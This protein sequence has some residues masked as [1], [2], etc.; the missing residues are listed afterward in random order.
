VLPTE[1]ASL[2]SGMKVLEGDVERFRENF[3]RASFEFSHRLADHPLFELPRLLELAT[4]LPDPDVYYDAGDVRVD[5][6]WDE[7][8]RTK[9]T[10]SQLIERIEN[11]GAWIILRG[12]HKDPH[13]SALIQQCLAEAQELV[14]PAF[15]RRVKCV[16]GLIF[17][18]SP[19][20]VTTYHIDRECNFLM[21][22]HGDKVIHLF[23]RFD[24]EVLP[25]EEI[26]R[27][28]SVDNNAA[29]FKEQYQERANHYQLRPGNGVHIPVNAPHWL[30][31]G[32]NLSVT[33]AVTFQSKDASL[34]NVYRTNHFLRKAGLHPLPPGRSRVRDA[35]KAWT[36]GTAV[37]TRNA[38]RRVL[39]RGGVKAEDT[40][41]CT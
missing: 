5:Q 9:L 25:E 38:L 3:N 1:S 19:N 37:A 29:R 18:T 17:I 10:V 2:A 20:R 36:M 27:F 40:G 12:S 32:D 28:W 33:L 26:E 34:P 11:A 31:N 6:R 4:S 22:V 16:R 8:P 35:L 21:Q 7:I 24:R 14:G 30:K 15:P 23:D 41:L 39:R 13:Y